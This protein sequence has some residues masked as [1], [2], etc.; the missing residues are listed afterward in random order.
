MLVTCTLK[1]GIVYVPTNV[2]TE[3]GF[4]MRGE[5]VAVVPAVNTDALRRAFRDVMERGN[6]IVPTPKRNAFPTPVLPKYAGAKNWSAFMNGASEWAI[7][8]DK[9]NYDIV[10]YRKDPE[11][12]QGWTADNEH[13][14]QFP[15]GTTR[16]QVIEQIIKLIQAAAMSK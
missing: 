12:S 7:N 11:G 16:D 13:R 9:G 4:Y 10:P 2:K 8:E 1:N 6:E 14:I 5:P 3:A 15:A